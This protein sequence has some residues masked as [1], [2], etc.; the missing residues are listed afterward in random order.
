VPASCAELALALGGAGRCVVVRRTPRVLSCVFRLTAAR[1][2][3]PFAAAIWTPEEAAAAL[4]HGVGW[5]CPLANTWL[6]RT[7]SA[8]GFT[9]TLISART[10]VEM[11][12]RGGGGRGGGGR[13]GGRG[14]RGGG[15]GRGGRGGRGAKAMNKCV[16]PRASNREAA[17]A[18]AAVFHSLLRR[19]LTYGGGGGGRSGPE[20]P[21]RM[22]QQ[23]EDVSADAGK[24]DLT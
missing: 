6:R 1:V 10:L 22:R 17:A 14:G 3:S 23:L 11:S 16:D 24:N 4:G 15:A 20:L 18:A 5:C 13:G 21:G 8:R 9:L 2:C 7:V 19:R 12:G